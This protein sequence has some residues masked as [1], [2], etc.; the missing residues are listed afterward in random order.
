MMGFQATCIES[1]RIRDAQQIERWTGQLSGPPP[2]SSDSAGCW[3]DWVDVHGCS[4]SAAALPV[5]A[6][7]AFDDSWKRKN[8]YLPSQVAADVRA[9][10][11]RTSYH[12]CNYLFDLE[13][14][15]SRGICGDIYII[16]ERED[17]YGLHELKMFLL[18]AVLLGR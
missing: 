7:P 18:T 17:A 3:L 8:R 4:G 15:R 12:S 9:R 5:V 11:R 14:E 13:V 16:P 6:A 1:L 10:C 2:A